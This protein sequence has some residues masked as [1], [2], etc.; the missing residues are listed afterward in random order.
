M[1]AILEALAR[2]G[3][4][5]APDAL[6][7]LRGEPQLAEGLLQ[8]SDLPFLLT[9]ANLTTTAAAPAPGPAPGSGSGRDS[10]AFVAPALALAPAP[11]VAPFTPDVRGSLLAAPEAGP[12][13]VRT[14]AEPLG[15]R[16]ALHDAYVHQW[17]V[18][19]D[20]T[21]NSTCEG[22]MADFAKYFND[23]LGK[24]RKMLRQR[25]EMAAAVQ[26]SRARAGG[27]AKIP[28]IG[29]VTEVRTT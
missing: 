20:V 1:Q 5:V 22:S 10:A 21:G 23:R 3:T 19:A 16:P 27:L 4:L 26:I 28:L 8:R 9:A 11:I 15:P 25:R 13:P 14:L 2:R 18:L 24:L 6:A 17:E 12:S 29:L 7:R